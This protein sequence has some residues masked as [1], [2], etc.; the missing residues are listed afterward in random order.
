[1]SDVVL[2]FLVELLTEITAE[3]DDLEV[4][5]ETRLG[6]LGFDSLNLVYVIAELQQRFGLG[7][8]LLAKLR[9][10]EIDVRELTV[11]E[12]AGLVRDLLQAK[13]VS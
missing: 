7:D 12:A 11:A 13:V 3:W 1:V 10:D 4:N 9:A 2:E 8:Q 5:A 6:S